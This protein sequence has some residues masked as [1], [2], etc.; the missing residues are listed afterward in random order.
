MVARIATLV[1]QASQTKAKTQLFVEKIEQ[2]YSL[3]MVA[4]TIAVFAIP[5]LA[6]QALSKALLRAMTFMIVASPCAVVLATMPPL[7]AAIANAGRHGVLVKSAVAMEQLG[8]TTQLAF[9]K[10][11]T[12]TH[13]RPTLAAIE[14]LVGSGVTDDE[15]LGLAAA[16]EHP[17]EHPL[18]AAILDAASQRH[19]DIAEVEEFSAQP[20]CGVR[21]RVAGHLIQVGSPAVLASEPGDTTD[22]AQMVSAARAQVEALQ[23][24]GHTAVV[25]SRDG[26]PIAVLGITD[27]TRSEAAAVVTELTRLTGTAPVLLTGDNTFTA[28]RLATEVGITDVRA[29][30]LPADK[31]SAIRELENAGARVMVVGD[32]INDAPALA[33]AHTGIA[34]GAAGSDLALHSADAVIVRDDLTTIPIVH[35]HR[36]SPIAARPPRCFRQPDHRRSLHHR[37]RHL[38]SRRTPPPTPRCGRARRLHRH[39]RPQ[40]AAPATPRR[41]A[42]Q[43]QLTAPAHADLRRPLRSPTSLRDRHSRRRRRACTGH[44][45]AA[46]RACAV[47]SGGTGRSASIG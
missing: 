46:R 39:R 12:L 22:I 17:S 44:A 36:H 14:I 37:A 23:T 1:E 47:S 21:A 18:A 15:V 3:G 40:R 13:G 33:A 4:A 26:L 10:T 31:V 35:S 32:G 7:L 16:V 8:C 25:V 19:L 34:M 20:G 28:R 5:L 38:G 2:R 6:G 42:P 30:L 29:G 43:H 24:H 27:Q 9:D 41:V 45:A 11:G